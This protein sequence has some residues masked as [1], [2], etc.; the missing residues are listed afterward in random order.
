M[1]LKSYFKVLDDVL[2]KG[3]IPRPVYVG[4]LLGTDS[5]VIRKSKVVTQL[6]YNR[7]TANPA[8]TD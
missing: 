5:Q 3:E 2:V 7:N 4:L 6:F 8:M 1:Q